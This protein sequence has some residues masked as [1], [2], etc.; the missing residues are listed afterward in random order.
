MMGT[1][2]P[3]Y[4]TSVTVS[5]GRQGHAVSDDGVLDVQLYAPKRSG[6]SDG[7]NPEQLFAAAWAGCFGSALTWAA[8]NA[9]IEATDSTV[10]VEISQGADGGYGLSARIFASIPGIDLTKAQEL[11][12]TA[13]QICPYSS[14]TRG[15]IDVEVS[16]V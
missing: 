4:T 13:H 6:V 5:G 2:E 16:A 12:E 3:K 15:N 11:A 1:F 8:S 14:A 7:T 9:G 10:K